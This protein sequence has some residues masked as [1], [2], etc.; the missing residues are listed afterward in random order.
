LGPRHL[1]KCQKHGVSVE[2]IEG[3]FFGDPRYSPDLTHSVIEQRFIAV[4]HGS[5]GRPMFVVFTFR[6][7]DG[8]RFVRPISARYMHAKEADRYRNA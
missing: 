8:A 7:R 2:E 6:D 3:L 5:G 1:T 4:G